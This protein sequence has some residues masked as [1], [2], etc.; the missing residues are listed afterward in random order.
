LGGV[1]KRGK[2]GYCARL[3][4]R[5][6]KTPGRTTITATIAAYAAAVYLPVT[7]AAWDGTVYIVL[8]WK[9]PP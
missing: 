3:N 4:L 5:K 6:I 7:V 8:D 9:N 2:R 1:F